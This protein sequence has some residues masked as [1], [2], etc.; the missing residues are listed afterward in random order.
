MYVSNGTT[1][2]L[3]VAINGESRGTSE[4]GT[5][6]LF[7]PSGLAEPWNVTLTT[8]SGRQIL[9]MTYRLSDI[10]TSAG[11]TNPEPGMGVGQRLD[12]SCGRL[13]VYVG[14]PILGGTALPIFSPG[15]CDP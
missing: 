1:L 13:D 10:G 14:G 2:K 15:D 4:P 6:D 5:T 11:G 8:S 7:D 12:L 3:A 9:E